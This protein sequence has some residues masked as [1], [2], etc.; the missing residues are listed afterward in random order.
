M[1]QAH[2]RSFMKTIKHFV[3]AFVEAIMESRQAKARRFLAGGY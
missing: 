2:G 1:L 3:V